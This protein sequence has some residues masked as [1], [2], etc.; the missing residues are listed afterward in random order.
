MRISVTGDFGV[1][2]RNE[3]RYALNWYGRRLMGRMSAHVSVRVKFLDTGMG[4]DVARMRTLDAET[5]HRDFEI[6]YNT[7]RIHTPRAFYTATS[8]ESVHVW[9]YATKACREYDDTSTVW[10]RGMMIDERKFAYHELP[11]EIEAYRMEGPLYD[12]FLQ[13][14]R[15]KNNAADQPHI[16]RPPT[17]RP[18]YSVEVIPGSEWTNLALMRDGKVMMVVPV[19]PRHV[20]AVAAEW[21]TRGRLLELA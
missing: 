20:D 16:A 7:L 3:V 21:K 4:K 5:Q 1:L 17:G 18:V 13:H 8:H 9:Q 10:W 14:L 6:E 19:A 12:E 2:S 11:W 15:S